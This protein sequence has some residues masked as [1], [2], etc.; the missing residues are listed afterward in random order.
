MELKETMYVGRASP[1]LPRKTEREK[2]RDRVERCVQ[3][4]GRARVTPQQN[5]APPHKESARN[6][7][8][9][10]YQE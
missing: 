9:C 2:I 4:I 1:R 3:N 10:L 5:P 6:V 8:G 7:G